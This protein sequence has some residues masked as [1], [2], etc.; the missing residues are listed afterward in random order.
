MCPYFLARQC[1][2]TAN[3]IVFSYQYLLDPKVSG[4]VLREV[5]KDSLAI[6]DEAHNIDDACIESM[7]VRINKGCLQ[8]AKNSLNEINNKIES[9]T[10]EKFYKLEEEYSSLVKGLK[11]SSKA[12]GTTNNNYNKPA[13]LDSK[14]DFEN[15]ALTISKSVMEGAIPGNI[16][17][18]NDFISFIKRALHYLETHYLKKKEVIIESPKAF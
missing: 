9:D 12:N 7:T 10:D 3:I 5:N 11:D 18:A 13:Y 17:R 4:I 6:F 15:M 1:I 14:F 8:R 16:R 2:E